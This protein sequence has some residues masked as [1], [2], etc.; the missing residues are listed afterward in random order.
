M[1]RCGTRP[2]T[3]LH[4]LCALC[5][6]RL[7]HS[8]VQLYR[9]R[10]VDPLLRPGLPDKRKAGLHHS[11]DSGPINGGR[12]HSPSPASLRPRPLQQPNV[13][14]WST[15]GFHQRVLPPDSY[16]ALLQVN[17]HLCAL[18]SAN[19]LSHTLAFLIQNYACL[20]HRWCC[21]HRSQKQWQ[22]VC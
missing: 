4:E 14:L 9:A 13:N 16:H 5:N 18:K 11:P 1:V 7:F 21:K 8:L 22:S 10:E 19:H 15:D 3:A 6:S 2:T 12:A 17:Y 20:W